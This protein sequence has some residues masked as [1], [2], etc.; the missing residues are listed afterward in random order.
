MNDKCWGLRIEFSRGKVPSDPDEQL[1]WSYRVEIQFGVHLREVQRM[2][3]G[4]VWQLFEEFLY[5]EE[6]KN[7]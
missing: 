7:E 2:F 4:Q 6:Q 1:Q 3:K 5:E